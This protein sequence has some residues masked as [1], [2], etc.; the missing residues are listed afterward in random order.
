MKIYANN[1]YEISIEDFSDTDLWTL[2]RFTNDANHYYYIKYIYK[3]HDDFGMIRI[4][5]A[6]WVDNSDYYAD[7]EMIE[8]YKKYWLLF[9]RPTRFS[10]IIIQTPVNVLTTQ[11]LYEIMGIP[12]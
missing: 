2:G 1:Q 12:L 4:F 10:N 5:P 11:E 9:N 3:I 8:D 7:P 6:N